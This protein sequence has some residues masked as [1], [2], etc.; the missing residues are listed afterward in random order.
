M[1]FLVL[2]GLLPALCLAQDRGTITGAVT[3][4]SGSSIPGT[5]VTFVLPATGLTQTAETGADGGY[6]FVNLV[7]GLYTIRAEA[8]GFRT[9]QVND[10]QVQVNTTTRMDIE[11][12]V[13]AVQEVVEVVGEAPLLQAD[14][15]DLG[16][17]VDNRAIEKLPLFLS[18]GLRSNNAFAGL[19]PGV[20][21]NLAS[22]PDTTGGSP[23]IAGGQAQGASQLVDGGETMSERRN[24]PQMRAV[25]ADGI[26]E[27][28]VQ[29]G[30]YSAEYGRTSNGI[31]NYT[32][33][34]GTN[35]LHGTFFSQH[36]NE[37][38]N[39][40]GFFWGD[41][42]ESLQRQTSFAAAIGGPVYIPKVF[43]GRNKA[44]WFFSGERSR[45]KSARSTGLVQLPIED[46]R[47]GDF[48]R[49]T[50]S[51]GNM[52]P[53]YDPFDA[54]GNII[55]DARN[56]P[57][58]GCNGVQN[59]ICPNRI[60][61]VALE[62]F[63]YL[64]L[65]DDPT[66]V[67]NN[68]SERFNGTR[69]PGALAGVYSIKGDYNATDKLRF[70]GMFSTQYFDNPPLIGP[71]PGPLANAFQ[72]FGHFKYYRANADYVISPTLLNHFTFSHN[73]R[74]LGEGPNLGLTEEFRA[75]TLLP[76]VAADKS[77][78]YSSYSTEFGTYGGNVNTIS[79]GRTWQ[80]SDQLTWIKGKHNFKFGGTYMRVNYRRLDC[81]G[82]SGSASFSA[83]ATG[84]PGVSGTT[85]IQYASFLLGLS[86]GGNFNYSA[87]INN[88]YH[89]MAGYVQDDYKVNNK[90]TLNLGL[91]YDLSLPRLEQDYQY[92]NFNPALPNPEAGGLLGALEFA[93][94]GEGRTGRSRLQDTKW[95]AFGPRFGFAY[96]A[97]SKTVIRG[98]ASIAYDSIREDGN[99]DQNIQGFG[100]RF[101]APR[102]YL[103]NG[104]SFLVAN[105]FDQFPDLVDATRPP[106]I[107]PSLANFQS[108]QY[109]DPESGK[110]GYFFDYNLT[111][112][113]AFTANTLWRASFHANYG[114][115]AR[116][117]RNYNLLDPKYLDM[118]GSLL[119][120]PLSTAM[121][122]QRVI[123]SGF[124]LPYAGYPTNV[125]LQ[126]A[127]RPF[128]QYSGSISGASQSG[129]STWNAFETSFEKRFSGGFYALASYTFSK[130]L[131]A[132]TGMIE[133]NNLTE[134]AISG[135]DR[136]HVFALSYIYELPFGKGK[137]YMSDA[138]PFVDA[139]LGGWTI[140]AVHRYQSGTAL[141]VGCGQNLYGVGSARCNI[142]PG[143]PLLNPNWDRTDQFSTYLNPDAFFEPPNGVFG[144]M[145]VRMAQ[146]R[147]PNQMNEDVAVS[148][149]FY[150]TEETNLEFRA[151][152]VNVANRH[153]LGSLQTNT[154]SADFGQ[155]TNPQSNLPRG[156]QF[157]LRLSF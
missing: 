66:K 50:N 21:M 64:P 145:P 74:N 125:Q 3:D 2:L 156:I 109:K 23:R 97:T 93:G 86:S 24:D 85:G 157:S 92:S 46:F 142:V 114:I 78:N 25:S 129:H 58:L 56:R 99:A 88:I 69:T 104:I 121:K 20:A 123:D 68:T 42:G 37:H 40:E 81:N 75:A 124:Q 130:L 38:L 29:S 32:T 11:L 116:R 98:G 49:Y 149:N 12:Q 36:R 115:N 103:S 137:K 7:S 94:D 119:T 96:R 128:P 141:G 9:T 132:E 76:G 70:N 30:A 67:F 13:G 14:K 39:A 8:E 60:S 102:N 140:S 71:I 131:V 45:S 100:G 43:D 44:F 57:L 155:F 143:Q 120:T 150:F 34:S 18:G 101:N 73:R 55:P 10:V 108:P 126:Q 147:Q 52:V 26:E 19:V 105:G 139:L 63:K 154:R 153:L 136:P 65:P 41:R 15:S 89:Y 127:L 111:V 51:S 118:F 133:F 107:G 87:D 146:M 72:E 35:E 17:V 112:E 59:V 61:P 6:T 77:P 79:P 117:N 28:K 134:K 54:A 53:L 4:P 148:K 95:N 144:T 135:D 22:D 122:D 152:A 80:A 47:N 151:S 31:M 16:R 90:L 27:F 110:P 138:N 62:M 1:R 82:C 91:R 113:H 106:R 33:K 5:K 83:S 48:R 84:N